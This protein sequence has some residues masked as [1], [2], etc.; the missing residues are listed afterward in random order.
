MEIL[1]RKLE[2]MS[3][4]MLLE[5]MKEEYGSM[6]STANSSA[7]S[8]TSTSKRVEVPDVSSSP[9]RQLHKVIKVPGLSLS[10]M[11]MHNLF[12]KNVA[13]PRAPKS[14]RSVWFQIGQVSFRSKWM[15]V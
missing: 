8:Y 14:T 2:G 13:G 4:G 12:T 11:F 1:R 7:A 6:L 9:K 10:I 3:K 15:L 5:R